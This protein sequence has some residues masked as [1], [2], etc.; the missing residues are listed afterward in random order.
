MLE[1][2]RRVP[3]GDTQTELAKLAGMSGTRAADALRRLLGEGRIE[4]F[5]QKKHT[6]EETFFRVADMA[7]V[8][9]TGLA[10]T[11]PDENELSGQEC[12]CPDR[13]RSSSPGS[14]SNQGE[15]EDD[16]TQEPVRAPEEE[17]LF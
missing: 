16:R 7:P 17:I 8:G 9:V 14:N 11:C 15:N 13:L 10:R 12:C 2:A 5:K 1:A 6:R 4:R 3:E